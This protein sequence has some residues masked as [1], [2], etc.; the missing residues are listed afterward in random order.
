MAKQKAMRDLF[1]DELRDLYDAERQLTK[2][3]PKLAKAATSD[4]LR[5]ALESHR[6]ETEGHIEKLETVFEALG[7]RARGKHC[8]GIAGIVEEGS[9]LIGEDFD[10]AVMDAG[11]IAGAQRA[12]HYEM[13]AYGSLIAWANA[14]GQTDVVPTLEE[15]LEEEKAADQKLSEL[16]EGSINAEAASQGGG[17]EEEDEEDEDA[18]ETEDSENQ[19]TG[20][21][22]TTAGAGAGGRSSR[23]R[24]STS[25]RRR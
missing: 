17:D 16:A 19:E 8:A 4:D 18:E 7:E 5:E 14:L 11:I 22:R 25:A 23:G 21:R 6:T 24:A 15:I 3:L 9:D 1:L 12:E 10:G 2:A 20:G 13:G